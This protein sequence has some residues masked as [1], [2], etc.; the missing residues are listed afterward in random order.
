MRGIVIAKNSGGWWWRASAA[1]A[2][3]GLLITGCDNSDS[4]EAGASVAAADLRGQPIAAVESEAR[5]A[6]SVSAG[7]QVEA[8][9]EP[10]AAD[11]DSA[12]AES[13]DPR[14]A[15][16]GGTNGEAAAMAALNPNEDLPPP[17]ISEA[18]AEYLPLAFGKLASF[19]YDVYAAEEEIASEGKPGPERV[20]AE[21]RSLNGRKI[22]VRGF[23]MPL[24]ITRNQAKTFLLVRNRMACCFGMMVGLNEW[25]YVQMADGSAADWVNDVPITVYGELAV[26]EEVRDGM[27][28]SLYR[29]KADEVAY[30]GGF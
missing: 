22:A 21:I 24:D 11:A 12:A 27:V 3:A 16:Q 14:P 29:M 20:P 2:A 15:A 1:I 13:G 18:K 28:M 23:M 5:A 30:D 26:G 7:E 9:A 17:E 25:V 4:I 19:A 6:E 10:D 8:D